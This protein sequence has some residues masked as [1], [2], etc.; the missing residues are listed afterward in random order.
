MPTYMLGQVWAGD[1]EHLQYL[2][3]INLSKHRDPLSAWSSLVPQRQG[4]T[5]V[6]TLD[7]QV[8]G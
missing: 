3:C 8:V 1:P 6:P 7:S 4:L 5:V 2:Q